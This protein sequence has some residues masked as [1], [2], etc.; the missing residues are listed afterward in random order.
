MQTKQLERRRAAQKLLR[1]DILESAVAV[2]L[3][4]GVDNLTMDQVAQGA[5]IAKGTLY[6]HFKDKGDLLASLVHHCFEPLERKIEALVSSGRGPLDKLR[7][8]ALASLE[9]TEQNSRLF[10]E[11]RGMIFS[12]RDQYLSD[13]GSWYWSIVGAFAALLDEALAAGSIR[14]VNTTKVAALFMD[15]IDFLMADRIFASAPVPV[16]DDVREL[17]ALYLEG[18]TI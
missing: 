12:T 6:L 2:L 16:V 10:R 8:C 15:S 3:E 13:R 4:Q 18:L 14:P 11:L 1:H 5:G 9:H 17:M 7:E